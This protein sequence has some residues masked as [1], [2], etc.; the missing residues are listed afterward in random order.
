MF[1]MRLEEEEMNY[2]SLK[3][4]NLSSL[5]RNNNGIRSKDMKKLIRS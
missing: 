3:N 1:V 2:L 5:N 4:D